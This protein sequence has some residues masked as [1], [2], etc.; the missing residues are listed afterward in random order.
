MAPALYVAD[1]Y[2]IV[3][4]MDQPEY[5]GCLMEICEKERIDIVLPLQ[6]DEL[7]LIAKYKQMFLEKG[8]LPVISEYEKV[9]LCRDKYMLNK[10]LLEYEIS[11][12]PTFLGKEYLQQNVEDNEVIL[13]PRFGAGSV[14]TFRVSNRRLLTALVH[15]MDEEFVV[16][17]FMRGK[18]FGVDVYVDIFSGEVVSCFCKEK[19]RMRA[20]ETEKSISVINEEIENL[21]TDAVTRLGLK[22]PLD[23]D[24]MEQDGVYYI[25]EINPRFG[26]GYPHAYLCGVSFPKYIACNGRRETN[27]AS[28]HNYVENSIA[29][30]YSDVFI[31]D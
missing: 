11:A 7:I 21:V 18:E 20:G 8:I 16:Q 22:G 26:G 25:L 23:V 9:C 28:M 6:E 2:Y 1:S 19:L 10:T 15:E 31:V 30:K 5:L 14:S 17:P 24:I 12:V 4:R 13:K 3:P 29:L 27:R